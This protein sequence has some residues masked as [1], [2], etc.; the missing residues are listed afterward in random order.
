MKITK[1]SIKNF[2]KRLYSFLLNPH[3]ILCLLIAWVITNGWAYIAMSLGTYFKIGW[4]IAVAGA[5]I[6]FLWFPFTLE[7]IVTIIIAIEL[8]KIFFPNDKRTLA[9]LIDIK[10][11]IKYKYKNKKK[12]DK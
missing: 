5:Y 3:L 10:E 12:N 8:L 6:S 1:E 7:K 4:L 2:F 11:K 9:V